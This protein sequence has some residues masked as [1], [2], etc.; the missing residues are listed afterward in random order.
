MSS[1]ELAGFMALFEGHGFEV[2]GGEVEPTDPGMALG[3]MRRYLLILPTYSPDI[4]RRLT[5]AY[6][7]REVGFVAHCYGK[8]FAESDWLHKRVDAIARPNG[9]GVTPTVEGRKCKRIRRTANFGP[10][11]EEPGIGLWDAFHEYSFISSPT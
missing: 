2:F 4:Q 3:V 8:T 10:D 7:T 11:R 6:S 9:W 1:A 5:G